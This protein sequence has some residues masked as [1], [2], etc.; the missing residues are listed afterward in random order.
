MPVDVLLSDAY[1]EKRRK[2]ITE[3]A[4][5][6]LR[7]G[8]IEGFGKTIKVRV[9]DGQRAA[10]GATGAGEPTVGNI[11][12]THDEEHLPDVV[13]AK[14]RALERMGARRGDTVHFDVVDRDGNI[15]SSTPSGGWLH[16]SP[17]IPT[18]VLPLERA[19]RCSGWRGKTL[20]AR[21]RQAPALDSRRPWRCATASRTS[22]GLARRRPAGQ[23]RS[24]SSS[25]PRARQ[26]EPA[27][28]I[29]AP[30]WHSEHSLIVLAGTSRPA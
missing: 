30:A 16:S 3:R 15:V 21:A 11:P 22:L 8:T 2:L 7:P 4:S 25:C 20:F 26:D 12:W 28:A 6:E 1:N 13:S 23:V 27:E 24:R 29:D 9:A 10:V 19:H 18:S 14:E 5:L 17:V